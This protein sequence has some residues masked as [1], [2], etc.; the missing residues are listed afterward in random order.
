[1]HLPRRFVCVTESAQTPQRGEGESWAATGA[2]RMFTSASSQSV[3]GLQAHA[4]HRG[5]TVRLVL[6]QG[7]NRGGHVGCLAYGPKLP[8]RVLVCELCCAVAW[9]ESVH[10]HLSRKDGSVPTGCGCAGKKGRG[11][12][13][14]GAVGAARSL[15][16]SDDESCLCTTQHLS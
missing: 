10:A 7:S 8:S 6:A 1:M 5:P 14:N 4:G 13:V 11:G 12:R 15:P 16:E 9:A 3:L 2:A